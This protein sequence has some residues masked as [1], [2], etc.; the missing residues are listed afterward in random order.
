MP[1]AFLRQDDTISFR[2]SFVPGEGVRIDTWAPWQMSRSISQDF[3]PSTYAALPNALKVNV[4]Q[5]RGTTVTVGS[6]K[7]AQ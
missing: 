5:G 7:Y 1:I 2:A 6:W 3:L 4:T